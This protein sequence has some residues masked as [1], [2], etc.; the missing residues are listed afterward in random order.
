MDVV[1]AS[2]TERLL[3]PFHRLF[4][5]PTF[6]RLSGLATGALLASGPR[7]VTAGLRAVGKGDD[8][9]FASF[10][11][12][13]NAARWSALAAARVL[14][15][16]LVAAFVPQGAV[17]IGIDDTIERR[18]G[19]RIAAK[20]IYRDPVRS[21]KGCFVKVSGLRW[22]SLMVLARVPFAQAVWG[23]PF[24]TVL[25]PSEHAA[26]TAGKRHKKLTDWA[27]QAL[28][29]VCRWLPG[30]TIVV[31]ADSGYAVI[32]LGLALLGRAVLLSRLR[33]DARLFEPA[34]P[35]QPGRVGRP[36]RVGR[37]L[38]K[39]TAVAE[40]PAT[41]WISVVLASRKDGRR[42]RCEMTSGTAV[43]YHPGSAPLPIRWI[44]VRRFDGNC[45]T[46]AFFSTDPTMAAEEMLRLF[47]L[48]WQMEVTFAEVRQHLGVETQRQ[49]SDLA[50]ARATP[51]LLGLFSLV[52]LWAATTPGVA[53]ATLPT[54]WYRKTVPTFAD[55]L[56]AIRLRIWEERISSLSRDRRDS[57]K[58]LDP[59]LAQLVG[60]LTRAA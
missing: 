47:A 21:S 22:L 36:R 9:G 14:L 24:L 34:P 44:L 48:R 45:R 17:V 19:A 33:L 5:R 4:T 6:A 52:A 46:A 37:E 58:S 2:T 18:K 23:L 16:L 50:I 27:R 59:T 60:I 56:A 43:W 28:L 30:R 49:W 15:L 51:M 32:E 55:A 10:H 29:Q 53:I 39:L 3:A 26:A 57:R 8:A 31:V 1:A 42:H 54:A 12:V 20:G 40:D 41:R 35:R 13:L 7:T 25:C 11:R 38:P